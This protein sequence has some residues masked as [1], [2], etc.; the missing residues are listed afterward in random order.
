[1]ELAIYKDTVGEKPMLSWSILKDIFLPTHWVL[2][3]T[4]GGVQ[5]QDKWGQIPR[6]QL[7]F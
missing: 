3:L 2:R 6:R 4:L 5:Q 7:K 1:M